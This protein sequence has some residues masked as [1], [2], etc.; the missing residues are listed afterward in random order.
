METLHNHNHKTD[1]NNFYIA[2]AIV[3]L[4]ILVIQPLAMLA[5][6]FIGA[7]L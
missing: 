5:V 4:A 7:S 6:M 3:V 1:V 2:I